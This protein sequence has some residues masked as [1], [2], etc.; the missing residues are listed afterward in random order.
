[1]I[2]IRKPAAP[3]VLT[4]HG[5]TASAALCAEYDRSPAAY[6]QGT[7]QFTFVDSIYAH[8]DV[9][10]ALRAAQHDKCAFCESKVTHTGYGD[11]EHF[12]PKGGVRQRE[13]D[14][15]GYPGYYWLAYEWDNLFFSCQL[16][17]QRFKRNCFPLRVQKHRAR[18]HKADIGK[19]KP[20]LVC[21]ASPPELH[22]TFVGE[23]AVPRKNS[24]K[25]R[26]TIDG[27]G[28]N[29]SELIEERLT[30]RRILLTLRETR[31]LLRRKTILTAKEQQV[32]RELEDH[33]TRAIADN[34]EYAGMARVTLA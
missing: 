6:R 8:A 27:L 11:V 31:D 26:A 9:K 20:L 3:A 13:T 16:C 32:L 10:A 4:N 2:C 34:A 15:L 7:K 23:M 21:P 17:N 5:N 28:L 29:R 33:M 25:G 19:E 18:S 30:W 22:L 24:K 12:R 14:A 1:M